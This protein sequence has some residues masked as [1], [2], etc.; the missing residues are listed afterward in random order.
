MGL[1]FNEKLSI[2]I[3]PEG[4]PWLHNPSPSFTLLIVLGDTSTHLY[5][6]RWK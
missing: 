3:V 1:S 4:F 6:F 2:V 5:G